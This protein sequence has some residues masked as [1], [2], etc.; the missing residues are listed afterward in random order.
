MPLQPSTSSLGLRR[1]SSFE[2]SSSGR[3]PSDPTLESP[4]SPA[5]SV[6][7]PTSA[8]NARFSVGNY[9]VSYCPICFEYFTVENPAMVLLCGHVFH[10]Q[11]HMSWR[12]RSQTCAVCSTSIDDSKVRLM[13]TSDLHHRGAVPLPETLPVAAGVGAVSSN[14]AGGE[15]AAKPQPVTPPRDGGN[16]R[17]VTSG[18]R[19]QGVMT[20]NRTHVILATPIDDD[21]DDEDVTVRPTHGGGGSGR[22]FETGLGIVRNIFSCFRCTKRPT[23]SS[24]RHHHQ[25]IGASAT[26]ATS[27]TTQ[28]HI[29]RVVREPLRP[30]RTPP[31]SPPPTSLRPTPQ[32]AAF[33]EQEKRMLEQK[34]RS[35]RQP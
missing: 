16:R 28:P 11:C 3:Q 4:A 29:G 31:L 20:P 35:M 21:E 17:D 8:R 26:T 13:Q 9:R 27:H 22:T 7:S 12:E 33:D 34:E 2:L 1:P 15:P 30:A 32:A 23:A 19:A 5:G 24:A 25:P 10:A 14:P 6:H 18:N